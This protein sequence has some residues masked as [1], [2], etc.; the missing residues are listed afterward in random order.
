MF[1]NIESIFYNLQYLHYQMLKTTKYNK[2][3]FVKD[4]KNLAKI[5]FLNYD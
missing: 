2:G 1:Y 3:E 5:H 4:R